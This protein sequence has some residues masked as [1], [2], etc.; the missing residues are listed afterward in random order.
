MGKW[1]RELLLLALVLAAAGQ[2][3]ARERAIHAVYR[4]P[5]LVMDTRI[6]RGS[7]EAFCAGKED[8]HSIKVGAK[9]FANG[10]TF[11]QIDAPITNQNIVLV[12]P[13]VMDPD[14]FMELLLEAHTA[15]TW[16]A[17]HV[18][19]VAKKFPEVRDGNQVLFTPKEVRELL[20]Q[21]GAEYILAGDGHE[22]LIAVKRRVPEELSEMYRSGGSVV[23]SMNHPEMGRELGEKLGVPHLA[24]EEMDESSLPSHQQVILV[25]AM[26]VPTNRSIFRT[27]QMIRRLRARG[28]RV[29]QIVP[30]LPYVRS[31]KIDQP[32]VTVGG[33]LVADLLQFAGTDVIGFVKLHSAQVQGFFNIPSL[34]IETR[35]AI[36]NQLNELHIEAVVSPDAGFQK[37]ATLYAGKLNL[38]VYVINKQR[39]PRTGESELAK[40]GDFDV[41]GKVLAVI[42]DETASGSTLV[43]SA[44]FLKSQGASKVYAFVTHLAGEAEKAMKSTAL[45]GLYVTDTFPLRREVLGNQVRP[46]SVVNDI[47]GALKPFIKEKCANLLE[48]NK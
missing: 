25:S 48:P 7:A 38:P 15:H 10:N 5:L 3:Q 32:G 24:A 22:D 43:S 16:G 31:D 23:V 1:V 2:A 18:E 27:V 33:K 40:M 9:E 8:C 41:R 35:D 30:Y 19:I 47:A 21:S 29:I 36:A 11:V 26:T 12:A 13:E 39:N 46:I 37:E 44:E 14:T 20:A 17:R 34:H 28:N 6:N 42:D 4:G 45:D